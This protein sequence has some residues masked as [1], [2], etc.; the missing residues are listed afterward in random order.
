MSLAEITDKIK[1]KV[2][3]SD[4]INGKK[5]AFD[6][7]DSGCLVVDGTASPAAVSNEM[8]DS[9]CV[10]SMD[11]SLFQSILSGSENAQMAFMSGKIQVKGDMNLA[12][13]LGSLLG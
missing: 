1:G 13:Q 8:S 6:F 5:V 2:A 3:T 9:D 12:M 10:V 7:G 11:I 4:A